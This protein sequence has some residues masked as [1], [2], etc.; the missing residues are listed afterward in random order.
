MVTVL[1]DGVTWLQNSPAQS[2]AM[3]LADNGFDVWISNIRGTR[4]SRR[5]VSL[6]PNSAVTPSFPPQCTIDFLSACETYKM[7]G[8]KK[9][10]TNKRIGNA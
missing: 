1:Q 9:N 6:D 5:H 4:Y 8:E 2:P 7:N 10:K 3:I